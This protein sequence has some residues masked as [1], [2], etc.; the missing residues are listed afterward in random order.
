MIKQL[1]FFQINQFKLW[2]EMLLVNPHIDSQI[3]ITKLDNLEN[4]FLGFKRP[5]LA[6]IIF[7]VKCDL[8]RVNQLVSRIY[9]FS[10]SDNLLGKV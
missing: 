8:Q 4:S 5:L 1:S 9:T 2:P 10:S 6:V 3:S 7:C